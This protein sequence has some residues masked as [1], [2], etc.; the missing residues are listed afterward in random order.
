MSGL[1]GVA[2]ETEEWLW[3]GALIYRIVC[4]HMVQWDFS[5]SE[6]HMM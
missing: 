3:P 4:G 6:G 1:G 2:R 5:E